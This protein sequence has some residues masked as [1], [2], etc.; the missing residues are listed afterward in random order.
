MLLATCHASLQVLRYIPCVCSDSESLWRSCVRNDSEF[1]AHDACSFP[2][3][4]SRLCARTRGPIAEQWSAHQ[5]LAILRLF[6][7]QVP[8]TRLLLFGL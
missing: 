7:P 6:K 3:C 1:S 2:F 4:S 8:L 5:G